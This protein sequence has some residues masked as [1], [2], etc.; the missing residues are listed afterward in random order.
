MTNDLA[1]ILWLVTM[2]LST[3]TLA[4]FVTMMVYNHN[5]DEKYSRNVDKFIFYIQR[6][7]N[8][9]IDHCGLV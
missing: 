6:T 2:A 7:I 9:D 3:A 1:T 8:N 5:L 4:F